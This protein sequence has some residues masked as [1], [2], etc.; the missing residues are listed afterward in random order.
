MYSIPPPPPRDPPPSSPPAKITELPSSSSRPSPSAAPATP[1]SAPVTSSRQSRAAKKATGNAD[2]AGQ[3]GQEGF[4]FVEALR[5][6][7]DNPLALLTDRRYY[8]WV[9]TALLA[10]EALVCVAIVV[11]VRYT[12]IDF[13]T[14]LQ[15]AELFLH[16][17]RDYSQIEGESGLAYYPATHLYLYSLIH[18]LVQPVFGPV[19]GVPARIVGGNLKLAQFAFA[20]VYVASLALVMVV[21]GRNKRTPQYLLPLL[22][23]SKRLHSIYVL[24]LF[25]DGLAMLFFY[26][27]LVLYTDTKGSK[28]ASRWKWAA[29]TVLFSLALNTKMSILLFLPGLLY[30]LFVYHSPLAC[31]SHA[32]FLALSQLALAWPFIRPPPS[33][34][35]S[36]LLSLSSPPSSEVL[37]KALTPLRTY[38][39]QAYSF[40]RSFLYEF[41]VNWRWLEDEELFLSQ[42]FKHALLAAHAVG[43]VLFA[44]RWAEE[45][46]GAG[47]L[48]LRGLKSP[49]TRPAR[50]GLTAERVG[51]ILFTSNFIGILCARSLHCQFYAWMAWQGPWMVFGAGGGLW[52]AMQGLL[53][54]SLLE[55]A[56]ATYPSTT[57][58][59]LGLVVGLLV[60]LTGAYY[61][62]PVGETRA[63]QPFEADEEVG[64]GKKE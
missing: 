31:L 41:T 27:A 64:K 22:C 52:E 11:K 59:S 37:Q 1:S 34:P 20:G 2:G 35:L 8:W 43:L 54:L 9:A 56:F 23:I 63:E 29:G 42:G 33:I 55:Y 21:Y 3:A 14:Y 13:S 4:E 40:D 28:A 53:L 38:L 51:T 25:N 12:E 32:A 44:L 24:R 46:G 15:Q 16:G 57:Y 17:E 50:R 39:H 18:R 6:L 58:S 45:E 61:G 49:A 19:D 48:L 5:H 30:L 26:A 60:I 7:V 36:S 62:R 10:W 47:S